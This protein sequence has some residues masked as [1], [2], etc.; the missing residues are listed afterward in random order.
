[1][2]EKRK[3]IFLA[4]AIF[5]VHP[6]LKAQEQDTIKYTPYDLLSSY[7]ES[8]FQPFQKKNWYV[9]M[10]FSLN[11]NFSQNTPGL[12]QTVVDGNQLDYK[13]VFKGG[14]FYH[15]YAMAGLNF[16]YYQR[17][18][19]G[20][21]FQDPD[22]IQKNNITRGYG[23]TPYIRSAI[24]LTRNERLSFYVQ[25]E[26]GVGWENTTSR[27]VK[28]ID[29]VTKSY[30]TVYDM[31]VGITPGIT[32]FAMQNFAVEIGLNVLGYQV[33]IADT[34]TDGLDESRDVTQKINLSLNL[35]SLDLG[36]AYY[37]GAN[38]K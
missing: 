36:L 15:D 3:I 38:R 26:V 18:F 16:N 4:L 34:E 35:L 1:M 27:N 2:I 8:H 10:A 30:T 37:F 20:T 11:D 5:L 21:V 17:K 7:Y 25:L 6:F 29:E 12:I 13:L 28:N 22:T 33:S 23:F 19:T 9:G 14:Y 24:P 31:G 32:F